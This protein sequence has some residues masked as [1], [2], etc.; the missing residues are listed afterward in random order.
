M[1]VLAKQVEHLNGEL[2]ERDRQIQQ[3]Q[4]SI[5]NSSCTMTT[6]L[7]S[8]STSVQTVL[9]AMQSDQHNQME[10]LKRLENRL[11][12]HEAAIE[13]M[14]EQHTELLVMTAKANGISIPGM[15]ASDDE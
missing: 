11:Q 3:L 2:R 10:T 7:T 8:V 1:F 15:D 5:Q 14:A 4:S 12:E 9:Q 13:Q 6:L